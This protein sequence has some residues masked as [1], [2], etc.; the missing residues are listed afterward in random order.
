MAVK[1]AGL[2]YILFL[3]RRHFR[4]AFHTG[5]AAR[6]QLRARDIILGLP[7]FLI[8]IWRHSIAPQVQPIGAP[9]G[10]GERIAEILVNSAIHD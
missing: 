2:R 8:D 6:S 3:L 7:L 5:F 10:S 1:V 4:G 9:F